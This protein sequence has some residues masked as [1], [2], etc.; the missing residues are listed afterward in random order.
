VSR[1]DEIAEALFSAVLCALAG[2][3]AVVAT[4]WALL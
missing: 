4:V 3:G 2:A 1:H